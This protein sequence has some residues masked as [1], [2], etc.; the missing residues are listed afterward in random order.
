MIPTK[1]LESSLKGDSKKKLL[2]KLTKG[3]KRKMMN[4]SF[5]R[6]IIFGFSMESA[7]TNFRFEVG[8]FELVD[9]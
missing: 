7:R 9:L 1:T 8:L 5:L 2:P 3:T 4:C 6:F